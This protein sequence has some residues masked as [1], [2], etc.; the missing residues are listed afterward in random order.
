M[1]LILLGIN[2]ILWG[3]GKFV[4]FKLGKSWTGHADGEK[5][6]TYGSHELDKAVPFSTSSQSQ[7]ITSAIKDRLQSLGGVGDDLLVAGG[8]IVATHL[9]SNRH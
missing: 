7:G 6:D 4:D 2:L 1:H 3:A 5:R 8:S 9:E